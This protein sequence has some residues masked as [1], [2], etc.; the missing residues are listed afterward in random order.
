MLYNII[1]SGLSFLEIL[2]LMLGY[3]LA[4][5]FS[6]SLH[7]FAHAYTSTKFGDP[8]PR[9]MGRLTL[10]PLKHI[11]PVGFLCLVLFGFGWAKPV[12]INPIYYK[13]YKRD[14]S[15]VSLAGVFMNLVLA[16]V[17]SGVWFF[18]SAKISASTN[19]FMVFL[20]YFI[21]FML[22][23]NLSLFVF[24]LIPIY[25][26]DGFNFLKAITPPGNKVITFLEKYGT[27]IL[28]VFLVTPLFDIVYYYVINGLISVFGSFWGLFLW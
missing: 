2:S 15:I 8:T 4:L 6:F 5:L 25:P 14:M 10:N 26:L 7:E 16:F 24:N 1:G 23:L 27:I 11:D 28:F 9:L 20:K 12:A 19:M 18:T 22:S 17:F 21:Y 3:M 13:H